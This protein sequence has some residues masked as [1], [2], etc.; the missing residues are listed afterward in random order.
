MFVVF[1]CEGCMTAPLPAYANNKIFQELLKEQSY[2]TNKDK[3]LY[4]DMRRS[5]DYTDKLEKL[6]RDDSDLLLTIKL[7]A[8]ATKKMRL[9]V[10]G[11]LQ[12]EFYYTLSNKGIIMSTKNYSISKEIDIA[13]QTNHEQT[14][15]ALFLENLE[16]GE[17][18]A[19]NIGEGNCLV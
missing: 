16:K 8:V 9:R 14:W 1:Q 5:I 12:A 13:A 11:Y 10:T 17:E 3:K 15:V 6:T 7:K 4:I 19:E 2:F 18:K